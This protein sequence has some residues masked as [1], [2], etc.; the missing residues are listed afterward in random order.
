MGI[1][2]NPL[3][4]DRG[5]VE[6]EDEAVARHWTDTFGATRDEILAAVEK[7]GNNPETVRKELARIAK[8]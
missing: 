7:V 1:K 3:R 8:A 6:L 4:H 2:I 5:K